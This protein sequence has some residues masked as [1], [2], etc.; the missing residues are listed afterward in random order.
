MASR[1][2]KKFDRVLRKLRKECPLATPVKVVTKDLGKQKLCGCC[3]AFLTPRGKIDHFIIEVD[4]N[5]GILTA[6]DTLLH[7]WAH[8]MDEE[9]HGIPMEP[10]RNTWGEMYARVWRCYTG[11]DPDDSDS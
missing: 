8:A 5:L 9:V 3:Y 2:G 4:R 6:I 7:E 1:Y 11:N 10:H